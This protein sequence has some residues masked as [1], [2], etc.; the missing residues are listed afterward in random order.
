VKPDKL[1]RDFRIVWS[2][3]IGGMQQPKVFAY[4]YD[5]EEALMRVGVKIHDY[6]RYAGET[7]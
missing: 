2:V 4:G 5:L 6:R 7:G 3:G 1:G